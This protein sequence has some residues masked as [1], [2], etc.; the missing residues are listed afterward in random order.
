MY[1]TVY[2]VW[3]EHRIA[4]HAHFLATTLFGIDVVTCTYMHGHAA[5]WSSAV[6][7]SHLTVHVVFSCEFVL[8][9]V[10]AGVGVSV[11]VCVCVCKCKCGCVTSEMKRCLLGEVVLLG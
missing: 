9:C 5:S 11:C 8:I 7:T 4:G 3:W 1:W 10:Y 6:A 2:C